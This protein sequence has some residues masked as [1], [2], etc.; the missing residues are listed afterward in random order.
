MSEA[1]PAISKAHERIEA[2]ARSVILNHCAP[3]DQCDYEKLVDDLAAAGFVIVRA[4]DVLNQIDMVDWD[5]PGEYYAPFF[6]SC[7]RL[8]IAIED[9]FR[10]DPR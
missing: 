5:N 6:E 7:T 9:L 8:K 3:F 10:D 1:K 2:K 4:R